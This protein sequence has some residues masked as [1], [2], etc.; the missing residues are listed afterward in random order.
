MDFTES[1]NKIRLAKPGFKYDTVVFVSLLPVILTT[2]F[3]MA[4]LDADVVLLV[5]HYLY[6]NR[7][8]SRYTSSIPDFLLLLVVFITV[9]SY[10]LYRVRVTFAGLETST[11]MFK[12][13]AVVAPI[14]YISKTILKYIFGR[15]TTREWLMNPQSMAFH[16]LNGAEYFTGFPSGHMVVFTAVA[17]V[18]WRFQP[19]CRPI[20]LV[21]LTVLGLLLLATNYHFLSDVIA[22]GYVGVLVEVVVFRSV[23]FSHIRRYE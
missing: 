10:C 23:A 6:A 19:R 4:Y 8:W 12:V 14:S 22:G 13:L 11:I 5:K 7:G 21:V 15:V 16:W 17:A 18:L 1:K 20:C 2:C 9:G 3:C